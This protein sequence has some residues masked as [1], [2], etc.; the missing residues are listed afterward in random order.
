VCVRLTIE[1]GM[2]CGW[3]DECYG[4]GEAVYAYTYMCPLVQLH[5]SWCP[6]NG[7]TPRSVIARAVSGAVLGPRP[8]SPLGLHTPPA[9]PQPSPVRRGS[10]A[11]GRA[12]ESAASDPGLG[13]HGQAQQRCVF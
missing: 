13:P 12:S 8:F 11:C 9:S 6:Q 3:A 2:L 4:K 7:Q 5:V 10:N 1:M